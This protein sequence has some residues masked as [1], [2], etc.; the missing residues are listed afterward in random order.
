MKEKVLKQKKVKDNLESLVFFNFQKK[1]FILLRQK[2]DKTQFVLLSNKKDSIKDF[3]KRVRKVSF[4]TKD[5]TV[6]FFKIQNF[7]ITE[8]DR[9]LVLSFTDES[10]TFLAFSKNGIKWTVKGVL[11]QIIEEG[12][13]SPCK[14]NGDN[15]AFFYGN[16]DIKVAYS[17][18][19]KNWKIDGS[20]ILKTRD[21]FFDKNDLRVVSVHLF[22]KGVGLVYE[23][24]SQKGNQYLETGYALLARDNF[25]K[26]IWRTDS[27]LTDGCLPTLGVADTRCLGMILKAGIF[28]LYYKSGMKLFV[29]SGRDPFSVPVE[30]TKRMTKH[31]K[32]PIIWPKAIQKWQAMGTFNPGAVYLDGKVHLV[33]RAVSDVGLSTVGYALLK[34]CLHIECQS[35]E[36]IYI[37]G[38]ESNFKESTQQPFMYESGPGFGGCEDPRLVQIGE[39]IYMIYLNFNGWENPRIAMTSISAQDF[40]N[41]KWAWRKPIFLSREGQMHKNWVLFPEKINGKFALLSS[42]SPKVQVIYFDKMPKKNIRLESQ[43]KNKSDVRRWDNVMRGTGAPPIRTEHGWLV[44]YHAMDV[45]DPNKYKVGAMILDYANPEKILYRSANP[46]LEPDQKYENEGFKSGVVYVCG[47]V[48]VEDTL[49]V[50]YG[51]A[52]TVVCVATIPF[53][54]FLKSLMT[55]TQEEIGLQEIF[56][57]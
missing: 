25:S 7:H 10:K 53:Q 37:V 11:P 41:K 55:D 22:G 15:F 39:T 57:N 28:Y 13:L 16:K 36:P 32:N 46:I 26:I 27:P 50:Y 42:L 19:L 34:D 51:G 31:P 38:Q 5:F 44:L 40:L 24:S 8:F 14:V 2:L 9:E 30:T 54:A 29:I 45:R 23:S 56:L 48:V 33:Y 17:S 18:D 35:D 3:N 12:C 49:F 43:F 21:S 1:V 6:D 47:A 4:D 52:D 20:S